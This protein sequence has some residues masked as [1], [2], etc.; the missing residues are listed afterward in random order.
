MAIIPHLAREGRGLTS[1]VIRH[2]S[3]SIDLG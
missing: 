2:A 3:E 1:V